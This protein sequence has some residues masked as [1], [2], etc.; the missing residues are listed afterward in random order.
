MRFLF[1]LSLLVGGLTPLCAQSSQANDPIKGQ[2]VPIYR[3]YKKKLNELGYPVGR[4]G[5]AAW[6]PGQY[7]LRYQGTK[8]ASNFAKDLGKLKARFGKNKV[9]VIGEC[10]CSEVFKIYNIEITNVGGEERGKRGR[11]KIASTIGQEEVEPNY[12]VVPELEQLKNNSPFNQLPANFMVVKAANNN[13]PVTIAVLDTGI[14]TYFQHP[15]S[16]GKRAPLY[17]WENPAPNGKND[18]F[19]LKDDLIGWDFINKDNAPVDDHSHG[20]HVASRIA[21]QL[22]LNAPAVNYRFMSVKM[23][24]HDGVG[25][26]FHAACAVAYAALNGADIINA[27]WGFYGESDRNLREAFLLAQSRGVVTMTSAGNFRRDV[28]ETKHYP[29]GFSLDAPVLRSILFLSASQTGV[30]LWPRTNFRAEPLATGSH[31]YAAPGSNLLGF[32]P[33][34][35]GVPN[36]LGRKS[37]TSIATPYATAL[38]AQYVHQYPSHSSYLLRTRIMSA[39]ESQGASGS[40]SYRGRLLPYKVF[41]W[42]TF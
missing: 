27:S 14:D 21:Q 6:V 9:R 25:T 2:Y 7:T 17:L 42:V 12:Y 38:A 26:T 40:L 4:A 16:V 41:N 31:F 35:F 36:N 39:I 3:A 10:G 11:D 29:S 33:H 1:L 5:N 37:G 28:K 22:K 23:L 32:V 8:A 18:P 20:T 19:C 13:R 15:E 24:D 34:Y 30:Q